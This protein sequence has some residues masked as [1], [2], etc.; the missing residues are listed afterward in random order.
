MYFMGRHTPAIHCELGPVLVNRT[1]VYQMCR[2]I[3]GELK[4]RGFDVHCSALLA[5]LDPENVEPLDRRERRLFER[6]HRWLAWASR[7]PDYFRYTRKLTGFIPR[8]RH[9]RGLSLFLDPL[10]PLFFSGLTRGVV[11]AYDVSPVTD[12]GWHPAGVGSLYEAAY[13]FLAQSE[14]HI[15]A[16]CRNTADQL[17]YNWGIPPSRVTVLHLG[18]FNFPEPAETPNHRA[19]DPFF[20]FV[21]SLEPRKNIEGMIRAYAW[22][23]LFQTH[24]I[25]LR[26]VGSTLGEDHPMMKR[27]RRT[28]GVE[29]RGFVS[30]KELSASY[31]D[32][33]AFVY[34]S[35]C[36]GFGLPLLEAMHRGCLCLSTRT[37][38]SP[39]VAGDA[40]AYVNPYNTAEIAQG[41]R[42]LA[43]CS[44]ARRQILRKKA[45]D[46]ALQFP[47]SR[48]HDGLA[49]VL[50]KELD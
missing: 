6:S 26:L 7:R 23:R 39:E 14:F 45:R 50:R 5:R 25:R 24:G 19:E 42:D 31:R 36:E 20:L 12:P 4:R 43:I 16:S 27:A 8:W 35:F 46:R 32:C 13:A 40:A 17:R 37:G 28:P 18:L 29:V 48:F 3:P 30:E 44:E 21:G 1:A 38:A 22:S 49:D 15:I 47:W 9:A 2:Q 41:M 33:L 10:Y 11:I 34:P